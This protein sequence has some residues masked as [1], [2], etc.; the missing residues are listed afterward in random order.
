ME[1]NKGS[2]SSIQTNSRSMKIVGVKDMCFK[3]TI[4]AIVAGI[5]ATSVMANP[6]VMAWRESTKSAFF[7]CRS[8]MTSAVFS[9]KWRVKREE[10]EREYEKTRSCVEAATAVEKVST[11]AILSK[12]IKPNMRGLI[13]DYYATWTAG[14]QAL[15]SLQMRDLDEASR[16]SKET[17]SSLNRTWALIEL[18]LDS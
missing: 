4:L 6:E 7:E 15:P 13:K 12:N 8:N 3:S 18:E 10:L 2:L 14:M 16:A 5:Y 11:R 1:R 9:T 17:E